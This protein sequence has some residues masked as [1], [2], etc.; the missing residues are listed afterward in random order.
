M[1]SRLVQV[2]AIGDDYEDDEM[3]ADARAHAEALEVLANGP[4]LPPLD[5]LFK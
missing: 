4:E 1:R 2:P 5:D 3:D